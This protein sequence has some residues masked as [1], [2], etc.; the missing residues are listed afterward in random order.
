[1][2]RA[3]KAKPR[4]SARFNLGKGIIVDIDGTLCP[5]RSGDQSYAEL[6]IH[7]DMV[8]RLREYH[9]AGF[10]ITL[11]TSRN[12]RTFR[13][14]IGRINA[15]TVPT[16]ITWLARHRVPYDELHF[17]KPWPGRGGFYVDDKAIRPEEFLRL[18]YR[19]IRKLTK[20]G[21]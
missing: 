21:E 3:G 9:A 14:N 19:E 15:V 10:H 12:M 8:A 6:P 11:A 16:L 20:G 17:A 1:M 13:G 4:R 2:K 5:T 7:A 18:G